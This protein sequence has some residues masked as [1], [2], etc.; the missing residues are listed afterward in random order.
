MSN[1]NSPLNRPSKMS[2]SWACPPSRAVRRRKGFAVFLKERAA[3]APFRSFSSYYRCSS[4][5]SLV[6]GYMGLWRT[7]VR[8]PT[9]AVSRRRAQWPA[10]LSIGVHT[11]EVTYGSFRSHWCEEVYSGFQTGACFRRCADWSLTNCN[12]R[13]F[14]REQPAL[15]I[16]HCERRGARSTEACK[17][18]GTSSGKAAQSRTRHGAFKRRCPSTERCF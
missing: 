2:F 17:S 8:P 16:L 6:F 4:H 7:F 3:T 18:G 15:G 14:Q 1:G 5:P 13:P 11:Q 12:P 9:A 10:L